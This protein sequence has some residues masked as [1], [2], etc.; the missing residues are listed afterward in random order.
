M[1]DF[2]AS[3]LEGEQDTQLDILGIFSGWKGWRWSDSSY[4]T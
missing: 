4:S 2:A 3:A 1:L